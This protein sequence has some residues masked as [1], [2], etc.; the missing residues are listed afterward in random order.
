MGS[1]VVAR[2]AASVFVI[3]GAYALAHGLKDQRSDLIWCGVFCFLC[4]P[5]FALLPS[6]LSGLNREQLMLLTAVVLYVYWAW[7][8]T[9]FYGW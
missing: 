3:L 9:N 1:V 4:I 6:L 2:L 8:W 5:L 7:E